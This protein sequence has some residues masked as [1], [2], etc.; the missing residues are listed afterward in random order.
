[1]SVHFSHG[2]DMSRSVITHPS[3]N[4]AYTEVDVPN[5]SERATEQALVA[6]ASLV[7]LLEV[8]SRSGSRQ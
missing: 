5:F 2:S 3:T 4:R 6:T 1:M 7:G 8:C